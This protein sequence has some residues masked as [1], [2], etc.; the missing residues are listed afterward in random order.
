VAHLEERR[1]DRGAGDAALAES[2]V[3]VLPCG[4]RVARADSRPDASWDALPEVPVIERRAPASPLATSQVMAARWAP[5]GPRSSV[6]NALGAGLRL[7]ELH[8]TTA[9]KHAAARRR[10]PSA[11]R[12]SQPDRERRD[13][14]AS[15][16]RDQIPR[17]TA[18]GW[19]GFNP[20]RP[21]RPEAVRRLRP[22][23]SA[24]AGRCALR[25]L[26][27][28]RRPERYKPCRPGSSLADCQRR[29]CR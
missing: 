11:L 6:A 10:C 23:F 2:G 22:S 12:R 28:P 5:T 25:L 21:R 19:I 9:A 20:C 7:S 4:S 1:R 13:A 8:L 27:R 14:R 15:P 17:G 3:V 16:R 29:P 26:R 18:L 24:R